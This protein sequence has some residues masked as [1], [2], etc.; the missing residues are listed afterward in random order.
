MQNLQSEKDSILK[1]IDQLSELN[2][3][4]EPEL[5]EGREKIE[6]LSAEGEELSKIIEEKYNELSKLY[7]KLLFYLYYMQLLVRINNC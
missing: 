6:E 7:F 5:V 3:A 2:L 1:S 4:R